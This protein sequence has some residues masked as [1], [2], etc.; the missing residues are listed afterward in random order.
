MNW[1]YQGRVHSIE[2]ANEGG[3]FV[4]LSSDRKEAASITLGSVVNLQLGSAA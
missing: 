3:E 1:I 4:P 2:M